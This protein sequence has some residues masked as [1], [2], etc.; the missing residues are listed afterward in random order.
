M[1]IVLVIGLIVVLAILYKNGKKN[2]VKKII[3]GLVVQAE[4]A[5]GSGSGELKYAYVI[6]KIYSKL[7]AIIRL[8]YTQ[9][10][11]DEIIEES[12]Q[13]LKELLSKGV[14]LNSYNDEVYI[15]VLNNTKS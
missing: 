11:L 8:L 2:A 15:R 13:K 4:K 9:K 3:L 14:D 5:L 12:V 10:E 7:P 1:D 6:E